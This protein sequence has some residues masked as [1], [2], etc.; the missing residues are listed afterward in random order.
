M[1]VKPLYPMANEISKESADNEAWLLTFERRLSGLARTS[2]SMALLTC[3]VLFLIG[4]FGLVMSIFSRS[5][6]QRWKLWLTLIS[7]GVAGVIGLL[8]WIFGK[9]PSFL[10]L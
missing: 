4:C 9:W 5:V 6:R 3:V 2:I 10:R 7:G 1:I 8:S